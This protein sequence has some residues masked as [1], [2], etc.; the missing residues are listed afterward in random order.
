MSRTRYRFDIGPRPHFLTCTVVAWL[1]VFTRKEAVQ[2]VLDSWTFL[3][4]EGS[5]ALLGYVVLE[6]HLH[7]IAAG[8]DLSHHVGRFKSYTARRLIDLL[9]DKGAHTLLEILAYYKLRH[10]VDQELQLWQEG[11]HPQAIADDAMMWQ[12][13]EYLHNNPVNRGYVDDPLHWR[14]SSAR[15]YARQPGLIDVV[16]EW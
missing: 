15:N 1:P 4:R 8:E 9:E 16:T 2:I 13:L 7:F 10:K 14:Y 3:Q 11:S 5:I 12:K 6:N